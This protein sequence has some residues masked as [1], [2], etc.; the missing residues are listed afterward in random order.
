MSIDDKTLALINAEIDGS[1]S[2]EDSALLARLLDDDPEARKYRDELAVM[3]GELDN[4]DSEAVPLNLQASVLAGIQ[5]REKPAT[6]PAWQQAFVSW[7]GMP[8]LRYAVSF[9]AGVILTFALVSSGR[10]SE[11]AFD[12]VT[13]LVGTISD[14]ARTNATAIDRF[15]VSLNELSGTVNLSRVGRIA[16][17]D[18]DL[19]S[20][21]PI[22][23]VAEFNNRNIWFNGFA[24]LESTGTSVAAESGRFT[25]RMQGQRRY[26]VYLYSDGR[27][28]A[29]LTLRFYTSGQLLHEG[30]L[31]LG[32]ASR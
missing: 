3:C 12:D 20:R 26:A 27:D 9:G 19:S 31:R 11:R 8:A 18:F 21:L 29:T 17:V 2:A 5:G 1:N 30:Q 15:Q 13:S 25:V 28:R 6:Q 4:L 10:I 24:Q 16:I 22:E 23:I 32:E 7:L 14:A